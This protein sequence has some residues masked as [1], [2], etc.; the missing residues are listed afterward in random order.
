M[1]IAVTVT[2]LVIMAAITLK[3][4]GGGADKVSTTALATVIADEL[5]ASR[6]LAVSSGHPV[7]IGIP[8]N[9]GSQEVATSIYR[10]AGWNVPLVTWSQGYEGD[11]PRLGF[12]AAS[13][14]PAVGTFANGA[15]VPP[16]SKSGLFQLSEWIPV[17]RGSDSIICFTPDGGVLTN[18]LPA[19]DRRFTIV[20]AKD[21]IVNSGVASSG[22]EAAV[23]YVSVNGAVEVSKGTPGVT[24]PTSASPVA[25]APS[26]PREAHTGIGRIWLSQIM[27]RPEP[28][29]GTT[30][31]AFC[32]PGQQVTF[33]LYAYDPEGRE[34]FTQWQQSG[35]TP[36][37][38]SFTF[39]TSN[40]GNL[41]VE[42]ER[43]EWVPNPDNSSIDWNGAPDP[44]SGCFR[45]RW[46]WTV[47]VNSVPGDE[48]YVEADVKDATGTAT[49][50]NPPV[51]RTLKGPP[52][53]RLLAEIWNPTLNRW[54]IVRMNPDG[55]GRQLLTPAGVEEVMPSVDG[56]GTKMAYLSGPIG[57]INA[58]HVKIRS[59]TGG[60]E[61]TIAGPAQFT[62]VSISPDG[63]WVSYRNN[64]TDTLFFRK[65]DGSKTLTAS[66]TWGGGV[67]AVPKSRTGWSADGRFAVWENDTELQVTDLTATGNNSHTIFTY[68]TGG[69]RLFAPMCFTPPGGGG[70][71]VV[72]TIG[73][74]NPVL[75]VVRFG[76]ASCTPSSGS[77]AS[78]ITMIELEGSPGAPYGSGTFNDGLP[79]VSS[80][81]NLL[82]LPREDF[83]MGN[84]RS[85]LVA[86][87]QPGWPG[88]PTFVSNSAAP[89]LI[90]RDVRSLVWLP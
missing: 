9:G 12:A 67:A 15:P 11:Y 40:T 77:I 62:S 81:G 38:G 80:Q 27:V 61:F 10:L 57:N 7:A 79:S 8:T 76:S 41:T 68:G 29:S 2:L 51:R 52:A 60:G 3:G 83:S 71:F 50:Q 54:E 32:T 90:N 42:A 37:L 36:K 88:G 55:T 4:F 18:N 70:E 82:V 69:E 35:N 78:G 74:I 6:E 87:W 24:L 25:N 28:G 45:S 86:E 56:T 64:T 23:V 21:L 33:E 75:G 39:P 14:T 47:P 63:Q 34:L 22:S 1:E 49:I 31:D 44:L 58:R 43:M 89:Q 65:V 30:A 66:Q 19:L 73:N 13:W 26:V 72:F 59:L 20:V 84:T 85:A 46:T 53:G 48:F 17:S 5:R 16:L